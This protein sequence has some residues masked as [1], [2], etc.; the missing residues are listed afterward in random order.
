MPPDEFDI[1]TVKMNVRTPIILRGPPLKRTLQDEKRVAFVGHACNF[2]RQY[3]SELMTSPPAR[4]PR[5]HQLITLTESLTNRT[6]PSEKRI[7]TPPGMVTVRRCRAGWTTSV[8]QESAKIL[9]G[10][11]ALHTVRRPVVR[12]I[13]DDGVPGI[14]GHPVNT[15]GTRVNRRRGTRYVLTALEERQIGGRPGRWVERHANGTVKDGSL[16]IGRLPRNR[17]AAIHPI[18]RSLNNPVFDVPSRIASIQIGPMFPH[19]PTLG[20]NIR[21]GNSVH[22]CSTALPDFW[23]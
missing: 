14:G 12:I 9:A 3:A 13:V 21:W 20:S 8:S 11:L 17:R 23:R 10:I 4:V 16:E 19:R 6:E 15:I 18:N 5:A 1:D 7:F 2:G 22:H